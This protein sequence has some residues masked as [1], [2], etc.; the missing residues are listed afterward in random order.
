MVSGLNCPETWGCVDRVERTGT[1][2]ERKRPKSRWV[3]ERWG[4]NEVWGRVD[5]VVDEGRRWVV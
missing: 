3:K 1:N 4:D 5:G 2:Y